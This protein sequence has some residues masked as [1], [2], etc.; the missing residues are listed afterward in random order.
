[1]SILDTFQTTGS[2]YSKNNGTTP[3][4]PNL[5]KSTLHNVYSINGNPKMN[6]YPSPSSLDL[7]GVT[8]EKYID[9]VKK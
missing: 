9:K 8:P 3:T 2:P 6:G 7:N 5:G 4:I 1:M